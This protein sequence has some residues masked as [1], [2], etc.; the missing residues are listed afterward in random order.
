MSRYGVQVKR[1]EAVGLAVCFRIDFDVDVVVD[2]GW[3]SDRL[4]TLLRRE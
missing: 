2:D 1:G 4:G 3:L